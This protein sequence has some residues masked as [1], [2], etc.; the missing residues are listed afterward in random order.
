MSLKEIKIA[1]EALSERERCELNAWLQ[2]WPNDE[3]D[4]EMQ[5]DARAG[6]FADLA[7]EADEVF[8]SGKLRPF[9]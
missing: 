6:R 2:N 8:D 4:R 3:W 1:I 9:P 7:R 5:E